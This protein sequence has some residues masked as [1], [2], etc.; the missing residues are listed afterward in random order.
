MKVACALIIKDGLLLIAR[1]SP[2]RQ[3]GGYWEFPGGKIENN[4]AP[5]DCIVREIKEELNL[6]IHPI[7]E[8]EHSTLS[9]ANGEIEL[10]P[11]YSKIVSGEILL[12]AHDR[13]DWITPGDWNNYKFAPADIPVMHNFLKLLN[14]GAL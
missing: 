2:Q 5:E 13:I 12:S 1:R 11:F 4:E 3:M 10:I 8:L 9:D 14:E 6:V 7:R